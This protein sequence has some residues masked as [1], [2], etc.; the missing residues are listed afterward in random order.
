MR[1]EEKDQFPEGTDTPAFTEICFEHF[2]ACVAF[3]VVRG[4]DIPV[5]SLNHSCTRT[6]TYFI[7]ITNC[8]NRERS[9][10]QQEQG[11]CLPRGI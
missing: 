9:V 5:S 6:K 3:E 10:L 4:L 7:E 1:P 11:G 8:N 2:M